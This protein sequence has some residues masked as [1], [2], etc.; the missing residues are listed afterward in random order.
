[1]KFA[2]RGS[3]LASVAGAALVMGSAA[4]ADS[5]TPSTVTGSTSVGGTFDIT[6]K[7]GTITMGTPTTAQA[8]VMFILDTTG[9]M[10]PAIS[11]VESAFNNT[12]DALAGF[13]NFETGTAQYKDKTSGS[14]DPFD[15][16][17]G[18]AISSSA[19]ATKAAISGYTAS[20]GGDDPEQGLFALGQAA[21]QA[22]TM[23]RAGS[24]RI[25][26]IVGDAPAH[27]SPSHPPAAGGVGVSS[28]ATT[29]IS[30][31]VTMIALNA[32]LITH[33]SG[34]NHFGQF[35]GPGSL[36]DMGVPGSFNDFTDSTDLTNTVVA[37]V[38][39][40]FA[41]YSDVSLGLVG[42][43]PSDC[44]VSLPSDITGA[45]SR[46]AT[47]AF[48]FGSVGVKGTHAGSCSF[49]IGLFA[50]GGL[51]ATESD[52]ITVT[53]GT[54]P[55][56]STWAMM[57]LGFAGLAYAGYRQKTSKAAALST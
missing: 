31:G 27:S 25:E 15:Y 26:V 29:L 4:F 33:D 39:S 14:G 8:D 11:T 54:V 6:D 18:A 3:L 38:G 28:T 36:L 45:F 52:T 9:S 46:A 20:G 23:W 51:L 24:K 19:A 55:E 35:S 17:L 43:A 32:S 50:D 1:M 53:G 34:L 30:N 12:V 41:T 2:A 49:T 42:P 13:G 56:P 22:S 37:D 16:Q 57:L 7:V 40:S 48:D 10:G 44:S 5:L 47:H 21:T